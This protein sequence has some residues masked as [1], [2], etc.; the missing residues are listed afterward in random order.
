[1]ANRCDAQ[2]GPDSAPTL[3]LAQFR[4][5]EF[6]TTNALRIT[7]EKMPT[8]SLRSYVSVPLES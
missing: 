7:I 6:L 1:M 2:P 5:E 4:D 8:I 3:E